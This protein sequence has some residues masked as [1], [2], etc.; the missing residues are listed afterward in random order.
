[1]NALPD[2]TVMIPIC[3]DNNCN[4][5]GGSNATYHITGVVA[6]YIDYMEDSNNQNDALC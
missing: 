3:D 2:R 5:S 1:V 4:T 6:F